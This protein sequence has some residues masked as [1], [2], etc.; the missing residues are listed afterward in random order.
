[1]KLRKEHRQMADKVTEIY[2]AFGIRLE[3]LLRVTQGTE[4]TCYEFEIGPQV[5]PQKIV[6][7]RDDVSLMLSIPP[8]K[9]ECPLPERNAFSIEIPNKAHS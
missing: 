7:L 2:A 3:G 9:I 4:A 8:A 5:K 1:M 6:R